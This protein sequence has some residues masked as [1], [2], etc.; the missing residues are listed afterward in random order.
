MVL[1]RQSSRGRRLAS[2]RE[3]ELAVV[4]WGEMQAKARIYRL[5]KAVD[6]C[7]SVPLAPGSCT[8]SPQGEVELS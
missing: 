2:S 7:V 5:G 1:G 6:R 4:R 3:E 8:A